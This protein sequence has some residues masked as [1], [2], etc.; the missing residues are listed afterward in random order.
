MAP[1]DRLKLLDFR[2]FLF[3]DPTVSYEPT[4][5]IPVEVF[6]KPVEILSMKTRWHWLP[7]SLVAAGVVVIWT[8]AIANSGALG[9]WQIAIYM[10]GLAALGAGFWFRR[11]LSHTEVELDDLRSHLAAENTRLTE[12]R[13]QLEQLRKEMN[14]QFHEQGARLDK[15]QEALSNRL[16]AY[17]E[18]ME[19]PQP[20]DLTLSGSAK[21]EDVSASDEQIAELVRKDRQMMDLL[22]AETQIL[23]DNILAN[24]YLREGKFQANLLRD[25]AYELIGNV[26][27]IYQP[28][29]EQPLLET[30]LS[31]VIRSASRACLHFLVL[32]DDLPLNVKEQ[33]FN[34]IYGYIRN[35]V[36]A[37]RMYKSAEPYWPYVNTAMYLG[38]FAMG[39]NPLALGAWW[40]IGTLG[41]QGAQK[42]ATRVI[43]RQALALLSDVVRVI[44]YEVAGTYGGDFRYRDANWIY[45]AELSELLRQFP[46]SRESLSHALKEV[47]SLQLRSEYDRIFLYRCLAAHVSAHPE[48]YR[49]L[50]SL[51]TEERRAIAARL[52]RFTETFVHGKTADRMQKWKAAVERRLGVKVLVK[53]QSTSQSVK[54]QLEDAVRSLAGFLVGSKEREPT[55]IA[56]MLAPCK[57]VKD[58]GEPD[59]AVLLKKLEADAPYFFEHSDLDPESDLVLKYLDDLAYLH[60]HVRPRAAN[61]EEALVEVAQY[62]RKAPK[63]MHS[64]LDTHYA[65]ELARRLSPDSPTRKAPREVARAVLDLLETGEQANFL[66]GGIKLVWPEGVVPPTSSQGAHWLLGASTRLVLFAVEDDEP[67]VLWTG[68]GRVHLDAERGLLSSYCR[69][70]GGKW[71]LDDGLVY[72]IIRIPGAL[73]T[74]FNGYFRP[75]QLFVERTQPTASE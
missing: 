69:L 38:R 62:L 30:N 59:R 2:R 39:A 45:A 1:A 19:F 65:A 25:D 41:T 34:S 47:G 70:T 74:P 52:E 29:T 23:Y 64:M 10:G 75:L 60:V 9:L 72:P 40:F 20:L 42:I 28:Q 5:K 58:M 48:K 6:I 14:E 44:G 26:A 27:R 49:A 15:R 35:A 11:E 50:A 61:L 21:L 56:A 31:L 57:V 13:R 36:K 22:K 66:Y 67:K 33:S 17:H 24:K 53:V 54:V 63:V 18:W 68:E 12:E 8:A 51:A 3:N 37:Y 16:L 73:V 32:L 7:I 71:V 55:E 46:L 43:N 4:L